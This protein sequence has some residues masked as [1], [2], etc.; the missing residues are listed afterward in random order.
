MT[1]TPR[2]KPTLSTA[3]RTGCA[4]SDFQAIAAIN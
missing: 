4:T 1:P 3:V 2:P